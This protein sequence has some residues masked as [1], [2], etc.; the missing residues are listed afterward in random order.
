MT[1]PENGD[2][3]QRLHPATPLL[4]SFQLLYAFALGAFAA[5]FGI[6]LSLAI[7]LTVAIAI[8]AWVIISYLR[9]RYRVTD[10]SL[11]VNYGVLFRQ[12][13][14]IPRSRIQ[15]VDLQAG[16]LSQIL[17]VTTARIETAGGGA[18]EA[19]LHVVSREE[20][21]RLRTILVGP[22][23]EAPQV[24][25]GET[26]GAEAAVLQPPPG[27]YS[28]VRRLTPFDLGIAGATS[29]RAGVLIGALLGGDVLFDFMPTDWLL[30]RVLP[31]QYLEADAAANALLET[32]QHDFGAF[33]TGL[34]VLTIFFGIAGWAISILGTVA[35]YYDFTLRRNN[36][37]LQVSYGLFTRR[38]KGFR[39]ARVQNVQIE[40]PIL[41]RWLGLATLKVQT[42]GYGP[43]MKASERMEVLAP[44]ARRREIAAYLGSVYSEFDWDD[45]EWRPSHPR[46]RRRMFIRRALVIL[47]VTAA[48]SILSL[49]AILLLLTLIPAWLLANAHYK[50]LGHARS[51]PYVLV[52]EGLWTQR[53]YVV[54]VRKIQALHL[55]Q[56]PFQRRLGLATLQIET[57][58]NPYE[59]HSPRSIDL[60]FGYATEMLDG[61][62]AEVVG[63][64]LVF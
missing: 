38:E 30:Q 55:A 24:L 47:P 45:V 52:R 29:N 23:S 12:Q 28:L 15:N 1:A 62:A 32:A 16:M 53:T 37:E 46:A 48:L 63:T 11:L 58:G 27:H 43:A 36:G 3:W 25:H 2:D 18:T 14:V 33:L 31:P 21:N 44:I 56:T 60:G 10:D 51:G 17:R 19:T 20:G 35:R 40:E 8:A 42:A 22:G 34:F 50:H 7:L 64:G 57:A 6:G 49:Y 13:R 9:F 61:L 39:R 41:R 59:W 54:P 26:A 5:S 4:R